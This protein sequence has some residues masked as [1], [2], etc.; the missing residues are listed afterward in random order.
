MTAP[1]REALRELEGPLDTLKKA[2]LESSLSAR[3]HE[4]FNGFAWIALACIVLNILLLDRKI[5][6]LDKITFFKKE[7]KK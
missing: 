1:N 7:E 4:L 2:T 6:W 3:H 5:G